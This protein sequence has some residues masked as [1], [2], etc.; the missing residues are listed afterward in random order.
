MTQIL[1][2][3]KAVQDA[4]RRIAPHVHRTPVLTSSHMD[5]LS[6]ASLFFKCENLQKVG[7]FKARGACNAVFALDDGAAGRGVLTHSS[8]NHGQALCYAAARR[9]I[10]ATV[11]MPKNAPAPKKA[12]VLGYGGK[13]VECE[14]TSAAR[15]AT[16]RQIQ[17]ESGAT[18]IHPYN[19]PDVI[20]GQ[21]TC[22]ME[23]L[24]QADNLDALIAP[25]GGGGLISGTCIAT[26]AL[27]PEAMIY[28][29][30]PAGADD[31]WQSLEAGRIVPQD[32]PQTIA[33]GLRTGLGDIT[34]HFGS[35]D[36]EAIYLAGEREIIAAMRLIWERM[37]LVVEPSAAVPLAAILSN[38]VPFRGRRVGLIL[39]G[40]NVDLTALPF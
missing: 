16:A 18:F 28:A 26:R 6:G 4:H 12:A 25:I 37:K 11:V 7:A 19:D 1:P 20:A 3:F 34:W 13:V 35:R 30:E 10:P 22:A 29:A 14:P 39:S 8:G 17:E 36:L 33:D 15:E 23:L 2:N 21:G 40:G 32:N 38:P 31:A 5:N 27:A 24:D 9:G